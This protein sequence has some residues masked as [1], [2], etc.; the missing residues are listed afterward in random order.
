[1]EIVTSNLKLSMSD[2]AFAAV[3]RRGWILTRSGKRA[4]P[5]ELKPEDI[6]LRDLAASLEKLVRYTGQ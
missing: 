6:C 4:N 5:F 3:R 2:E 1:M